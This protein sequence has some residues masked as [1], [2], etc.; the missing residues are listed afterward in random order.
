MQEMNKNEHLPSFSEPIDAIVLAGT[1]NDPSRWIEGR[2]K[3]FLEVGG[4]PLLQHVIDALLGAQ[5]IADIFIVGPTEEMRAASAGVASRVHLI[6]QKGDMGTNCWAGIDASDRQRG[7]DRDP[8]RPLVIISC[9]LPIISAT[10]IDDFVTRCA[11]DDQASDNPYALMVGL[12]DEAGLAPFDTTGMARPFVEFAFAR[13]RL[14]NIYVARP[15]QLANQA[16]L[17]TGFGF[18]KAIH[19][20]NV[21][22]LSVSVLSQDGGWQAAWMTLR[23][24]VTLL[25]ARRGGRLYRR[26]RRWNTRE[27]VEVRTSRVLGGPV[28]LVVSPFGGLSLDVDNEE[29]FR[30]LADRYDEWMSIHDAAKSDYPLGQLRAD[31]PG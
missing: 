10:S 6:Q 12:V 9:D 14:A 15:R 3:A 2:N 31:E 26:L 5:S 22:G 25:A 30:I 20:R 29:D 11:D 27:R 21:L 7:G 19:W 18:R 16:F 8:M 4:R 28:R 13:T 23:L 1:H 17:Q 24:Q